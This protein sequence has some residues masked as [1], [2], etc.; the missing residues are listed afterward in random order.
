MAF[1]FRKAVTAVIKP[2]GQIDRIFMIHFIHNIITNLFS[3]V[4]RPSS[5]QC[6]FYKDAILVNCVTTTSQ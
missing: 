3:L 4:F 2:D 6:S 5:G 1:G